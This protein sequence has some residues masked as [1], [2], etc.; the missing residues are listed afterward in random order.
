MKK[1][2]RK[3]FGVKL[4]IVL[5]FLFLLNS[6]VG[7]SMEIQMRRN[8]S[9]KLILEYRVSRMAESLGRLDGNE[10]WPIIP[11]GK[12]DFERTIARIPG[13][14]LVSFSS[15]EGAQD[16][17]TNVTLEYDN[18]DALLKF[19]DPSGRRASLNMENQSGR[20]DIILNEPVS[21][22]YDEDLLKLVRQ[23]SAG[24]GLSISFSAERNSALSFT[25]GEGTAAQAPTAAQTVTSG[26]KT[27]I[28]IG[29]TDLLDIKEGLGVSFNW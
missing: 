12:A 25:D 19:L 1:K 16:V 9:G 27:S 2:S 21:S 23:V 22:N 11:S 18:T 10:N 13:M 20:L 15:N 7:L 6:C 26:R 28:S 3:G 8:G 17:V 24:Y 29:I 14:R 5:P 4:L